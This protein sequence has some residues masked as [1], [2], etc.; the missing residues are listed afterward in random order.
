ML[1]L[2]NFGLYFVGLPVLVN[3]PIVG[4][5]GP[6]SE[7]YQ[8]GIREND[9]IVSVNNEP[10]NSWEEVMNY[11]VMATTNVVPVVTQRDETYFTNYLKLA[12]KDYLEKNGIKWKF[13]NLEAKGRVTALEIIKDGPGD[14]AGLKAQDVIVSFNGKVVSST[15]QLIA[16]VKE[17]AEKPCKIGVLRMV[18]E[19]EEEQ[20]LVLD[21]TPVDLNG[22]GKIMVSLGLTQGSVATYTLQKPGPLP[23]D[24]VWYVVERTYDT[25][26]AL[27]NHSKTGV[28]A[29][30]LSGPVGILAML[31]TFVKT[32]YRLALDFMILLNIN[33]A[34]LNL[35]PIPVLDGG[36]ILLALI[37]KITGKMVNMKVLEWITMTFALLLI[38][39]MIYVSVDD[40]WRKGGLFKSMY[41]QET[42]I[43]EVQEK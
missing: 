16:E 9:L 35:L 42:K 39:F 32:D 6:E 1:V 2:V 28:G 24:R 38:G 23:W 10:V 17:N 27:F 14:K 15:E 43:Q 33:L 40:I 5:V 8:M 12:P 20:E 13:L 11:S 30:D 18:G 36:H 25:I 3:P 41:Q 19:P 7:E 26:V 31:A 22:T 37:E 34:I 4:P 21:I 29:K